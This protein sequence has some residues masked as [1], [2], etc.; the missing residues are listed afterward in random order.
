MK[1]SRFI[2][3]IKTGLLVLTALFVTSALFSSC[4]SEE[5][6]DESVIGT[7]Y[8]G[9]EDTGDIAITI[10]KNSSGF[11]FHCKY[12]GWGSIASRREL[13]TENV[14]WSGTFNNLPEDNVIDSNGEEIGRVTFKQNSDYVKVTFK[15]NTKRPDTYTAQKGGE[16]VDNF[17]R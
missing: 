7:Y 10:G 3:Q 15:A 17:T 1:I 9:S 6:T 8:G 12:E 2:D 14:S 13:D 4:E 5:I 16:M 11:T